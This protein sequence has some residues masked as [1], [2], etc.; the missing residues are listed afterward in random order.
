MQDFIAEP[1]KAV[2]FYRIRASIK[3]KIQNLATKLEVSEAEV[4]DSLLSRA[5]KSLEGTKETKVVK[6]KLKGKRKRK[7]EKEEKEEQT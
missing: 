1:R 3:T 5:L 4:V 7:E 6:K 2:A